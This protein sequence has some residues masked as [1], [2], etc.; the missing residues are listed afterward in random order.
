MIINIDI[1]NYEAYFLDY[2]EGILTTDEISALMSFLDHHP[3]LKKELDE[4]ENTS[5]PSI[6][7]SYFDKTSLKKDYSDIDEINEE[8][9]DEFCIARNEGD[10]PKESIEKLEDYL[11]QNPKYN[12]DYN[13]YSQLFLKADLNLKFKKRFQLKRITLIQKR[14]R[15]VYRLTSAVAAIVLLLILVKLPIKKSIVEPVSI[16]TADNTIDPS[17]NIINPLFDTTSTHPVNDE[18]QPHEKE[19]IKS[20]T[21]INV[22][23]RN[24]TTQRYSIQSP[25]MAKRLEPVYLGE[26]S[27]EVHFQISFYSYTPILPYIDVEE[28][29]ID[30]R[31]FALQ[32]V[33][34]L[35]MREEEIQERGISVWDLADAGFKTINRFSDTDITFDKEYHENGALK[36]FAINSENFSFSTTRNR[37]SE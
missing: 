17:S 12:K 8:N 9:F 31:Q 2:V 6:S 24:D 32:K 1:H 13:T 28:D 11:V 7:L 34:S 23:Y 26:I 36:T 25:T 33:K 27:N 21:A 3:E 10:L 22:I 16:I 14:R 15:I 29:Y 37:R 30:F 5:I 4:F 35:F 18:S 20:S 19:R